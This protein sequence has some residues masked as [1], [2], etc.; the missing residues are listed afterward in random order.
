[1]LLNEFE[2]EQD[3]LYREQ[4]RLHQRIKKVATQVE[5]G[6][7]KEDRGIIW[8]LLNEVD[9]NV[10]SIFKHKAER[11]AAKRRRT[12]PE[13][14][15]RAGAQ[16]DDEK[17]AGPFSDASVQKSWGCDISLGALRQTPSKGADVVALERW[18]REALCS[19]SVAEADSEF[20]MSM[21]QVSAQPVS[22]FVAMDLYSSVAQEVRASP[23]DMGAGAVKASASGPPRYSN[24]QATPPRH[25]AQEALAAGELAD[26]NSYEDL[27]GTALG[28]GASTSCLTAEAAGAASDGPARRSSLGKEG[29][30]ASQKLLGRIADWAA[31]GATDEA[32]ATFSSLTV[33]LR[34]SN[35]G[36]VWGLGWVKDLF[37]EHKRRVVNKCVPDSIAGQWNKE[38]EESGHPERCIQ[39]GDELV[40]VNGKTLV[41]EMGVALSGSEVVLEFR[42]AAPAA[43]PELSATME[44]PASS[45]LSAVN[46]EV[47]DTEPSD[48]EV[49]REVDSVRPQSQ[50]QPDMPSRTTS[51][52]RVSFTDAFSSYLK[53]VAPSPTASPEADAKQSDG[54]SDTPVDAAGTSDAPAA[55]IG[56]TLGS[57][58]LAPRSL[59]F[60]GAG[61]GNASARDAADAPAQASVVSSDASTPLIAAASAPAST[62]PEA[63]S[64]EPE[65]S[66]EVVADASSS[67]QPVKD[68]A[69]KTSWV[70][71]MWGSEE[72]TSGEAGGATGSSAAVAAAAPTPHGVVVQVLSLG[73]GSVRLS[74][75]Y[76][77]EAAAAADP[78]AAIAPDDSEGQRF[79]GFEVLQRV[80]G[81]GT[82]KDTQDV[83]KG[84]DDNVV[85]WPCTKPQLK[86]DLKTGRR[87]SFEVRAVLRDAQS[88]DATSVSGSPGA[89]ESS[90][91]QPLWTSPPSA[92]AFADLRGGARSSAS[93]ETSAAT[94]TAA[95]PAPKRGARGAVASRLGSFLAQKPLERGSSQRSVPAAGLDAASSAITSPSRA[96]GAAADNDLAA[97]PVSTSPG[98]GSNP[99]AADVGASALVGNASPDKGAEVAIASSA[100]PATS[101]G[102]FEDP[103][104]TAA[105]RVVNS[106][107]L[108]PAAEK[109]EIAERLL[110]RRGGPLVSLDGQPLPSLRNSSVDS[111]DGSLQQLAQ[112]LSSLERSASDR[113]GAQAV[114]QE[115]HHDLQHRLDSS[116]PVRPSCGTKADSL[117]PEEAS[118]MT[119]FV[120]FTRS[121]QE[122]GPRHSVGAK[123]EPLG[124]DPGDA[125]LME[126]GHSN[127]CDGQFRLNVQLADGKA[128]V[129]EF[130]RGDEAIR[131]QVE[132]FVTRNK[133]RDIFVDP[134]L[135]RL[136]NMV[137]SNQVE[138]SVDV[139]DLL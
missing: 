26:R 119:P 101:D 3:M 79:R 66:S 112:A 17:D 80:E 61:D 24:L 134:L 130:Q 48:P 90:G 2:Q 10:S 18:L 109:R 88:S 129:L 54:A 83:E 45:A 20:L 120:S 16:V 56:D 50:A 132:E 126:S 113:L 124:P 75:L 127:A 46:E 122:Y 65:N 105:P 38:Q 43:P 99:E 14:N 91:A 133:L 131:H 53:V 84:S 36:V 47:D 102:A 52:R 121:Q 104:A 98:P 139:I 21:A 29:W 57:T 37:H 34:R 13:E 123:P 39:P 11:Q 95:G 31:G 28:I 137:L 97:A 100:V 86:L 5:D 74:W 70:S 103:L 72:R 108:N 71:W 114:A 115:G 6:K 128:E 44:A 19:E 41:E 77:W 92:L 96:G 73:S 89:S 12:Q 87:Y 69:E 78:A 30:A 117:V 81:G 107:P 58:D 135:E 82:D 116:S 94:T 136:S 63:V 7:R 49:A 35:S 60:S 85:R 9:S 62:A 118:F 110:I 22:N 59:D 42:R 1:M 4:D 55:G 15:L 51:G 32:G 76:D 68:P 23:V 64:T 138:D 106:K 40:S 125:A 25:S 67:S 33:V 111:D 27:V 93:A 8:S